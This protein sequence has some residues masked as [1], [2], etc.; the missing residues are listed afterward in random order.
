MEDSR[1]K[2]SDQE[3][4]LLVIRCSCQIVEISFFVEKVPKYRGQQSWKDQRARLVSQPRLGPEARAPA[5]CGH[6][7]SQPSLSCLESPI[8]AHPQL[9]TR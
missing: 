9:S 1:S 7:G 6:P 5:P 2:T 3:V 4:D 8:P